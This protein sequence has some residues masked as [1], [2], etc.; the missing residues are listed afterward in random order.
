MKK[1]TA[2]FLI[3]FITAQLCTAVYGEELPVGTKF[4]DME[5]SRP[6]IEKL[7]NSAAAVMETVIANEESAETVKALLETFLDEYNSFYTMQTLSQIRY[8]Q[9][10]SDEFYYAEYSACSEMSGMVEMAAENV[11]IACAN[12]AHAQELEAEYFWDGFSDDYGEDSVG[13]YSDAVV[14]LKAREKELI[15]RFYE[16]S[17]APVVNINGTDVELYSY[18]AS[19]DDSV[20]SAALTEYYRQYNEKYAEIFIE[21]VKLRHT[22][23]SKMGYKD[24]WDMQCDTFDRDFSKEQANAFLNDT[25][26]KIVPVYT[27]ML[28]SGKTVDGLYLD[29]ETLMEIMDAVMSDV[30]A[31]TDEAYRYMKEFGLFDVSGSENKAQVSFTS[32]LNRYEEPFS[33]VACSSTE[34]DIFSFSHEFGHFAQ[35]YASFNALTSLDLSEVY[36]QAM[37]M[38]LVARADVVLEEEYAELLRI[39]KLSDI[40]S[41]YIQQGMLARFEEIV[42]S[43]DPELLSTEMLNFIC[44]AC[45]EQFGLTGYGDEEYCALL[46]CD[47]AH[48]YEFPFYVISYPVSV[49]AAMQL[50]AAELESTGLGAEI[51][52]AMLPFENMQLVEALEK[53][54]FSSPF[55]S[56]RLDAAANILREVLINGTAKNAA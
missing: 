7:L 26:E 51:F 34:A 23:A 29:E 11:Y 25:A 13:R 53:A 45:A 46:W 55:E 40:L 5:Y 54:G 50:Y 22:L 1:L 32:Y 15:N 17:A 8:F 10:T 52:D 18:L 21:L 33:F 30:G 47:V 9:D 4:S 44:L 37:E 38:L 14:E 16:L 27:Q 49:D 6:N 36:S 31:Y 35:M 20:Y 28:A 2:L 48:L 39:Y 56:G 12:S 41:T 3:L 19:A 42:Y 24:V 43:V